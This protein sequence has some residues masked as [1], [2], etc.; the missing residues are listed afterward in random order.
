MYDLQ[1]YTVT[2]HIIAGLW[3]IKRGN[4]SELFAFHPE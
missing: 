4:Q 3:C 2:M 1:S